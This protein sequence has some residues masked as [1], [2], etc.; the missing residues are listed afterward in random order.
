MA[1]FL[2]FVYRL[3]KTQN[4]NAI[5]A[6]AMLMGL[7]LISFFDHYLWTLA[8]GRVMLGLMVGLFVGQDFKHEA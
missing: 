2:S 8:P 6:G 5:L 3:L 7:G 4:P 1:L